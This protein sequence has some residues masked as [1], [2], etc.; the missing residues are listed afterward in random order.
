PGQREAQPTGGGQ[1]YDEPD[2]PF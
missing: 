1:G 2:I